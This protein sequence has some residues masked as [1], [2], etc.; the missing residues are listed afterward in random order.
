MRSNGGLKSMDKQITKAQANELAA[1]RNRD[2]VGS[3][4]W[5]AVK[6]ARYGWMCLEVDAQGSVV[7]TVFLRS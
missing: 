7:D 5:E 1:Q 2:G 3:F 6:T 4:V